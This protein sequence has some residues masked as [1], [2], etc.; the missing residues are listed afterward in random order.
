MHAVKTK[1]TKII[2]SFT[3]GL[4]SRKTKYIS[5]DG[6]QGDMDPVPE[7]QVL[8]LKTKYISFGGIQGDMDSVPVCQ[9]LKLN[10]Q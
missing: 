5:F 2:K 8:K 10:V 6:I 9:V 1:Q 7:C 3:F 4:R